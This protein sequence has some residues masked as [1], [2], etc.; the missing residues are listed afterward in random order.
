MNKVADHPRA[1]GEHE[2]AQTSISRMVGSSPRL[3][4]TLAYCL[5]TAV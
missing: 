2:P 1:C 4:G 5:A 3:R